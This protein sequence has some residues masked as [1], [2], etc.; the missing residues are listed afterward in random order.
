[1][2]TTLISIPRYIFHSCFWVQCLDGGNPALQGARRARRASFGH[3]LYSWACCCVATMDGREPHFAVFRFIVCIPPIPEHSYFLKTRLCSTCAPM[4]MILVHELL[5][6]RHMVTNSST[7]TTRWV[8]LLSPMTSPQV[9]DRVL[10]G[11]RFGQGV[12]FWSFRFPLW[13]HSMGASSGDNRPACRVHGGHM[14]GHTFPLGTKHQQ[15]AWGGIPISPSL[16]SF[17][18]PRKDLPE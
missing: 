14:R 18:L 10:H 11:A 15:Q 6:L 7:S 9:H 2:Q 1:M 4:V 8:W 12:R 16:P 17:N 13:E 3:C 5:G